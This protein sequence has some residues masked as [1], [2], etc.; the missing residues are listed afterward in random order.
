MEVIQEVRSIVEVLPFIRL[1]KTISFGFLFFL[2]SLRYDWEIIIVYIYYIEFSVFTFVYCKYI[3]LIQ[4]IN[5]LI[6]HVDTCLS[7][8]LTW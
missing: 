7:V 8:F 2:T 3:I 6:L 5:V 4:S 1:L